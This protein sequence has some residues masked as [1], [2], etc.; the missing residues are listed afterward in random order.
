MSNRREYRL[1]GTGGQ[2]LILA[3]II[4]AEAAAHNG[5]QVVQTQ[6]YGPEARG[7]ASKAE[8]I[9][10]PDCINHPKVVQP[11][12]VLIMSKKAYDKYGTDYHPQGIIILDSTYISD[13]TNKQ[14][15]KLSI[16]RYALK[17]LGTEIVANIVAL[18]VI[19]A[20]SKEVPQKLLQGAVLNRAPKGTETINIKAL[21]LGEYLAQTEC[22][23]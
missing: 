7:G 16:T 17:E 10:A 9:T 23:V 22:Q 1:C 19:N 14:A 21:Q 20:L 4:L 15:V 5:K 13:S 18:G 6:S 11:H 3:S 8:V 2:G 12:I